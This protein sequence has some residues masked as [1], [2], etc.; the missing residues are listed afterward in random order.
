MNGPFVVLKRSL[1][2]EVE[3]EKDEAR[4]TRTLHTGQMRSGGG[5]P[6][7]PGYIRVESL[8]VPGVAILLITEAV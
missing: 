3:F 2:S 4:Q 1:D 7:V 6:Y 8:C 5:W